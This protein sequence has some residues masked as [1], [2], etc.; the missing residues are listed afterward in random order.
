MT[1]TQLHS[2]AVFLNLERTG[3][4]L[5]VAGR[6][7]DYLCLPKD[8]GVSK[9]PPRKVTKKKAGGAKKASGASKAKK[10]SSK[11][12]APPKA[13]VH[14]SK[15]SAAAKRQ[16]RTH[17]SDEDIINEVNEELSSSIAQ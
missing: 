10:S 16:A 3:E 7:A 5:A 2:I 17:D 1:L 14:S 12:R 11:K 13:A 15:K 6:I 9:A 4:K 8:T